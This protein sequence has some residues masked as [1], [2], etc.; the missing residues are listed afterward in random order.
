MDLR[1]VAESA[2][3]SATRHACS[4]AISCKNRKNA[5]P[6][7]TTENALVSR[8]KKK[9]N[10]SSSSA[11]RLSPQTILE[12]AHRRQGIVSLSDVARIT[13][14]T[15]DNFYR[16]SAQ[17]T[18]TP[19]CWFDPSL[20]QKYGIKLSDLLLSIPGFK[21]SSLQNLIDFKVSAVELVMLGASLDFLVTEMGLT[22]KNM[23]R[24]GA[25]CENDWIQIMRLDRVFLIERMGLCRDNT[26]DFF[27]GD[28]LQW[29]VNHLNQM[30]FSARDCEDLGL[31]F[32]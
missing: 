5:P 14:I 24:L 22:L 1:A 2:Y 8:I 29:N 13:G 23:H 9:F 11:G 25:I 17:K 19:Q 28:H 30:G 10:I 4:C 27:E 20:L 7:I 31:F 6:S 15:V 3:S 21:G 16:P 26:D 32:A 12:W 18:T